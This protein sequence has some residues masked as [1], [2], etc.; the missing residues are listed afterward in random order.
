VTNK[1][2]A[3]KFNALLKKIGGAEP[4]AMPGADDPVGVLITS[5]L[6]WD[7][8]TAE[9]LAAYEKINEHIVD[10]NDLRVCMPGEIISFIGERYPQAATRAQRL[11]ATLRDVYLREHN[12]SLER[13]ADMGK[14]DVKKYVET[15]DGIVPYVANRLMMVCFDIHAFPADERLRRCLVDADVIDEEIDLIQ[16][17]A[18]LTKHVKASAVRQAHCDLQAWSDETGSRSVRTKKKKTNSRAKPG[19]GK[20]ADRKPAARKTTARK[21]AAAKKTTT[22]KKKTAGRKK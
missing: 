9:T 6:M 21:S 1:P 17:T 19:A 7:A 16:L 10:N 20:A 2:S 8:T 18:W 4:A 22:K 13:V 15:L 14:R 11:R 5:F 3:T 12:I